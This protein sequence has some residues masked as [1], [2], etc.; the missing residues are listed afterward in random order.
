[1]DGKP[2]E[3]M[4]YYNAQI[5]EKENPTVQHREQEERSVQTRTRSAEA[6]IG[7]ESLHNPAANPKQ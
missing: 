6:T 7:P 3:V 1:K 4:Q 2:E 5:A